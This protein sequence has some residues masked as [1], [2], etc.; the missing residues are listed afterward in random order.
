LWDKWNSAKI[1]AFCVIMDTS[2]LFEEW[3]T[4]GKCTFTYLSTILWDIPRA[5]TSRKIAKKWPKILFG[6][7]FED[8]DN[9]EIDVFFVQDNEAQII[10]EMRNNQN[11][12]KNR[13]LY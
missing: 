6:C 8:W 7:K 2:R 1:L 5:E 4:V 13:I 12:S 3:N 11:H 10:L 9:I